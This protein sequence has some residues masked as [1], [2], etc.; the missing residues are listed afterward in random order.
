MKAIILA[1]GAGTRLGKYTKDLPKGMLN[2]AGKS[3]IERQIETLR[4]SNL[5]DIVI[6]RGFQA[7]KIN[8]PGVKYYLN[9][10]YTNTNM[11]ASL[12]CAEKEL[13]D[14]ILVCYADILYEKRVVK[15]ILNSNSDIGVVADN[16]Y[17]DYWKARLNNPEEDIEGF[18]VKDGKVIELGTPKCELDKA[19]IRYVGLIKFSK[20]GIE[21]LKE[22]FYENKKKYWDKDEPWL[23]SKSF[24]KAYMTDM[25]QALINVGYK[26]KPIIINNGWLEFDTNEDYEKVIK[27]AKEKTLDRFY[28]FER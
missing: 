1:A 4:A 20:K 7:N 13:N 23:N 24:K 6:V 17:W 26:V 15:K 5:E 10:D 28:S 11:V 3:L 9:E 14:D 8:F 25:L 22:V 18:V 16:S 27:W 19:M 21:A 2:F 12:F